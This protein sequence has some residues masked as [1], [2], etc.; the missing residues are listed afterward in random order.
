[1]ADRRFRLEVTGYQLESPSRARRQLRVR[2]DMK[3][4]SSETHE[5]L[6]LSSSE[7]GAQEPLAAC[8]VFSGPLRVRAHARALVLNADLGVHTL[9]AHL[10]STG[11]VDGTLVFNS[12]LN[13]VVARVSYRIVPVRVR[14]G[15]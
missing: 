4:A 8:F 12:R 13:D 9:Y 5:T 2:L 7:D 14:A 11:P 6:W 10:E 3:A 1:M 15:V